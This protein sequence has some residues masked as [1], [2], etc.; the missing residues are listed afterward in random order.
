MKSKLGPYMLSMVNYGRLGGEIMPVVPKFGSHNDDLKENICT[1]L[2]RQIDQWART[3]NGHFPITAIG[4]TTFEIKRL[5]HSNLFFRIRG[6]QMRLSLYKHS[7][8]STKN[9]LKHP[10]TAILAVQAALDNITALSSSQEDSGHVREFQGL[11]FKYFLISALVVLHLAIRCA[12]HQF[13]KIVSEYSK[14]LE[15]LKSISISPIASENLGKT[16]RILEGSLGKLRLGLLRYTEDSLQAQIHQGILPISSTAD[17]NEGIAGEASH[18]FSNANGVKGLVSWPS[19]YRLFTTT[20]TPESSSNF[21]NQEARDVLENENIQSSDP[22]PNFSLDYSEL[23]SFWHPSS[24]Q[25]W[26]DQFW[27][28]QAMANQAVEGKYSHLG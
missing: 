4:S 1:S 28:D 22:Y 10:K 14:G 27:N 18:F 13:G 12:P 5:R 3:T 21:D 24:D 20:I 25:V 6:N 11:Q 2:G 16:V 8:Y 26:S 9:I 17:S 7:L 15:T 23:N 19:D